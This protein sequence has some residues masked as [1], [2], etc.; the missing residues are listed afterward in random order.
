MN[1]F[2]VKLM[3][4]LEARDDLHVGCEEHRGPD[5]TEVQIGWYD[6]SDKNI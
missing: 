5:A 6:K 1:Q 2:D 4:S 3:K